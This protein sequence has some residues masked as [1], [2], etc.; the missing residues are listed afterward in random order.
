MILIHLNLH[1]CSRMIIFYFIIKLIRLE[2]QQPLLIT[3][4][5]NSEPIKFIM[6]HLISFSSI[7]PLIRLRQ[8]FLQFIINDYK[9]IMSC[10]I[11]EHS[12]IFIQY[13]KSILQLINKFLWLSNIYFNFSKVFTLCFL[14]R[15]SLI[16][17]VFDRSILQP[18]N[19]GLHIYLYFQ[20]IMNEALL[21][22]NLLQLWFLILCYSAGYFQFLIRKGH[23]FQMINRSLKEISVVFSFFI[24][25]K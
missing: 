13:F 25:I 5:L 22:F 20:V 14:L 12:L 19:Q 23:L 8:R 17:K 3:L 1:L 18:M 7:Y 10:L 2:N 15:L 6:F 21:S 4:Q 9:L 16:L 11:L 24:R